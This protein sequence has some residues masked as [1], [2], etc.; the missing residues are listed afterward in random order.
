MFQ[1]LKRIYNIYIKPNIFW[2]MKEEEKF[3]DLEEN[4][5]ILQ[6]EALGDVLINNTLPLNKRLTAAASIGFMSFTGGPEAATFAQNYIKELVFLFVEEN[7]SEK[8]KI[9]IL[10]S[11]AGICYNS[12]NNQTTM[13][14]MRFLTISLKYLGDRNSSYHSVIKSKMWMCYL[15]NVLCC[16]NLH[17]MK[18]LGRSKHFHRT[19][20]QLSESTWLGW[21]KNYAQLLIYLLGYETP[22]KNF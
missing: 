12:L 1:Q 4:M 6:M 8:D 18:I 15:L 2:K 14:N 10:Q 11:L 19:L 20:I 13:I 7:L 22:S 16:N 5:Q 21:P 3:W 9:T 17:A